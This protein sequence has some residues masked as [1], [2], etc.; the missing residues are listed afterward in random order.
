MTYQDIPAGCYDAKHWLFANDAEAPPV[1]DEEKE[2]KSPPKPYLTEPALEDYLTNSGITVQLNVVTHE[3]EV[4]GISAAYNPESTRNDL[5]VILYDNLK[6]SY[7]CDKQTVS[8]LLNLIA[9]RNRYNPVLE[10]ID[11]GE[12]DGTDYFG[13]LVEI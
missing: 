2:Q 13:Q 1:H 9:G 12:W 6:Q 8:D 10:L 3:M 5:P 7:R 4:G 11:C